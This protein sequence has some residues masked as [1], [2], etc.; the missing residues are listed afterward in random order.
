M[1]IL[2]GYRRSSCNCGSLHYH[3]ESRTT[4]DPRQ[5]HYEWPLIRR[6]ELKFIENIT[7]IGPLVSYTVE[8]DLFTEEQKTSFALTENQEP[9]HLIQHITGTG[10]C[11]RIGQSEEG[12][13]PLLV[14]ALSTET[15]AT[16]SGDAPPTLMDQIMVQEES[17]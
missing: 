4:L 3:D 16:L 5:P 6:P 14:N 1:S 17:D 2:N 10:Y 8:S 7:T 12:Q 15:F 11:V 13:L 9:P